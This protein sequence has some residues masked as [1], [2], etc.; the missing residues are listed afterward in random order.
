MNLRENSLLYFHRASLLNFSWIV[1]KE[2]WYE[3]AHEQATFCLKSW[4]GRHPVCPVFNQ[5]PWDSKCHLL[6]KY[7]LES[8]ANLRSGNSQA[9]RNYVWVAVWAREV[10]ELNWIHNQA[11]GSFILL[12]LTLPSLP[13]VF[14]SEC[15]FGKVAAY[16]SSTATSHTATN[17]WPCTALHK[18]L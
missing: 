10:L 17:P 4:E 7:T 9:S 18:L 8:I 14:S 13:P 2:R 3:S 15:R 6:S 12:H 16:A 11:P 1:G 5:N